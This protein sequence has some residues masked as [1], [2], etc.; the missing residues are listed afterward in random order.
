[1][2]SLLY[3]S[4]ATLLPA[5]P[6][7]CTLTPVTP[8]TQGANAVWHQATDSVLYPHPS[9]SIYSVRPNEAPRLIAGGGSHSGDPDGKPA[10]D[11]YLSSP[12][13][14]DG[15]NG[16]PFICSRYTGECWFLNPDG[17]V[18]TLKTASGTRYVLPQDGLFRTLLFDAVGN[19]YAY[20][21]AGPYFP[22]LSNPQPRPLPTYYRLPADTHI[23]VPL[24]VSSQYTTAPPVLTANRTLLVYAQPNEPDTR[25]PWSLFARELTPSA[26]GPEKPEYHDLRFSS[27]AA[28]NGDNYTLYAG[29]LFR[30]L[31]AVPVALQLPSPLKPLH[32]LST[33]N[34][35][36]IRLDDG[37]YYALE[38][39]D[40]CPAELPPTLSPAAFV[41]AASYG[42]ADTLSPNQLITVFGTNLDNANFF[43]TG[44]GRT[45]PLTTLF[46]NQQQATFQTP[47]APA[48]RLRLTWYG[49]QITYPTLLN[50]LPATPGIFNS[51]SLS[52]APGEQL[53]LFVT[54]LGLN[55]NALQARLGNTSLTILSSAAAPELPAGVYQITL[56]IPPT[57]QLGLYTLTL[58]VS[59]QSTTVPLPI[60]LP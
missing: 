26:L 56:Q 4:L 1:M 8:N 32:L 40:A 41:N 5:Q 37:V 38:N 57:A 7:A 24:Q 51:T 60:R 42:F 30:G 54:G 55:P 28:W 49:I 48:I 52:A 17:T 34:A 12:S 47:D 14:I 23:P 29:R 15:P 3:L 27:Q 16:R 39:P 31:P 58:Q 35:L 20:A 36:L 13:I 6:P 53:T 18:E 11:L 44:A 22:S 59:G 25:P 43:L 46:A 10:R 9:G 50:Y 2:R 21:P 45:Y 19:F 33:P